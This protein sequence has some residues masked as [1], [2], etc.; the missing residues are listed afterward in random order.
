MLPSKKVFIGTSLIATAVLLQIITGLIINQLLTRSTQLIANVETANVDALADE[1]HSN[2]IFV[3]IGSSLYVLM[4]LAGL[5]LFVLG[6]Y[7]NCKA[8][9]SLLSANRRSD[10]P[11]GS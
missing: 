11:V 6:V 5:M 8:T 4:I 2:S 10:T 3:F 7:Q 1:V 9:E